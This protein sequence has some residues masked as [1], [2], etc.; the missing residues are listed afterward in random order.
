MAVDAEGAVRAWV[1]GRTDLVGEGRPL[2]LGAHLARL[3]S[4]AQGA[5]IRLLRVGGVRALTAETPFDQARISGTIYGTTKETAAQA[6]AAYATVLE[7]L[8]GDP[9]M[10]SPGVECKVVDNITGPIALD[11]SD[12]GREQYRYLVDA[13]FFLIAVG[14]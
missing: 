2:P 8:Q 6:A 11:D 4:P 13:D 9:V 14:P 5:Y 1:N 7:G 12:S 10:M 3:R